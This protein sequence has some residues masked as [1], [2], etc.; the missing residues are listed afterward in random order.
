MSDPGVVNSKNYEIK[1]L[2]LINSGG[3]V[4][5]LRKVFVEIQI[6]QDIYSSVMSG[7]I[8]VNDGHDIFSN[9]YLCGN[10]YLQISIDKPTL[11][12][13]LEK[14]FRVYKT[15]SRSPSSDSGQVFILHFCSEEMIH[16][17]SKLIS[18]GYKSQKTSDIVLDV[19]AN[20]LKVDQSRVATIEQTSGVYDLVVPGYRPLEA[21]QW[22]TSR[23]YDASN[24]YCYFFYENRDGYNFRSY[25]SLIKQKPYKKLKYEIKTVDQDPAVNKDSIDKFTIKN[26]FD[27]LS[28]LSNGSFASRLLTVD[29]FDQSFDTSDYSLEAIEAAGNLLNKYKPINAL[30]N[31]DNRP[32]TQSY[33]SYFLT[34]V[35]QNDNSKKRENE[36]VKWLM[37]RTLH[38]A[39]LHNFRIE[40]IIPGDI[41]L[42]AGDI[43]EYEFPK[44]EGGSKGGKALDEY[45][46]GKYLVTA[47]NHKFQGGD[48]EN[49]E[50]VVELVSDSVSKQIP[51]AKEGLNKVVKKVQ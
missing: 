1:T 37:Q 10:E 25:N 18:K 47:V 23:S 38:I 42:K 26:D 33:D 39:L 32:I 13:P 51:G 12:K 49:F 11:D 15:T 31:A 4:V 21:I 29:I 5:D 36:L 40:I 14:V 35:E 45:R 22:V 16:S 27:I 28:S 43:V 8:T 19:L 46:T 2:D 34:Y 30:K 9:F 7:N 24:K 3:Q 17:N 44:F 6:Y 48:K 41:L 50:S 20:E